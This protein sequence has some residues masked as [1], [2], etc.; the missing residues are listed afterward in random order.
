MSKLDKISAA[1]TVALGAL[2]GV[3]A[4]FEFAWIALVLGWAGGT[5]ASA[6][7]IERRM[8]EQ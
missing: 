5:L 8:T 3:A 4:W 1:I 6:F 7:R 2:G